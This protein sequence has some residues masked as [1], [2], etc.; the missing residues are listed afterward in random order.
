MCRPSP[1]L[2]TKRQLLLI[3]QGWECKEPLP[4]KGS[5]LLVCW[6]SMSDLEVDVAEVEKTEIKSP[7]ND[8]LWRVTMSS[9][10]GRAFDGRVMEAHVIRY[11]QEL[12][13]RQRQENLARHN[14]MLSQWND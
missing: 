10:A 4:P 2:Y 6:P 14:R 5:K 13:E 3:L 8:R 7:Y 9:R 12:M 11:R 1:M